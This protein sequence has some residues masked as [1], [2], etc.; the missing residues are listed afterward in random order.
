LHGLARTY[1]SMHPIQQ[2]LQKAG[3]C[4][5]NIDYPSRRLPIEELAFIAVEQGL[6]QCQKHCADDGIH[7]VTHS[8]G[9]IL[10]RQYLHQHTLHNLGRVVMLAPPNQGTEAVDFLRKLPGY[11]WIN[12][13]AGLQLG[14]TAQDV[15]K[16]LGPVN[17][18][19]GVIAG[20]I[21]FNPILSSMISSP[22]DGKVSVKNTRVEGMQDFITLPVNHT[23]IMRSKQAHLQTLHFLQHG[24]FKHAD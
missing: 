14:T 5:V 4:V 3:Y 8:L 6:Q 16:K 13:P 24:C 18:E 22:D 12:G 15:P 20:E 23:F 17:F 10:V 2:V 11:Q 19:L 7:F 21:S 1:L 9:G